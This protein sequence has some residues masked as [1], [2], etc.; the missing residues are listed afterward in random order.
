[1]EIDTEGATYDDVRATVD[2]VLAGT[3]PDV[4]VVLPGSWDGLEPERR[5]PL[6]DPNLDKVL[7]KGLYTHEPRVRLGGRAGLA[8]F[9]LRLPP[10][11]VPG[12]DSVAALVEAAMTRSIGLVSVLLAETP[13]GVLAGRLER[14]AA[15]ARAEMVAEK[16]EDRDGVV[17][18]VYG[19]MWVD[20]ET[21]GIV[22][23]ADARP[24]LD[25]RTAYRLRRQAESGGELERLTKEV[26]RLQ[27]KVTE[28]R[29]ESKRWRATAVQLR[30]EVGTLRRQV[31]TL[32]RGHTLKR[33]TRGSMRRLQGLLG[34]QNRG[35]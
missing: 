19:S 15:F 30:R 8:P 25:G 28:W 16:D 31:N 21:Y 29:E 1:V 7:I 2:A 26:E 18:Q 11:W 6:A 23:A 22:P 17:N 20:A 4:S 3:L 27:D 33:I 12:E 9:V 5:A 10:G 14:T 34:D 35:E 13:D 24:L 32:K